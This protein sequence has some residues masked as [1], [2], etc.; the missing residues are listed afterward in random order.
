MERVMA[1]CAWCGN[2]V[3]EVSYAACARCGNPSN[4]SQRV[5]AGGGNATSKSA[6]IVVGILVGGLVLVAIL[7]IV[8]AIAIPNLLT[9]LQRSRQKRTVED[10]RKI[11]TAVDKYATDENRC[12]EGSS[13]D[14]L[15][16]ALVPKYLEAIPKI[17]AWTTQLRYECWPAGASRNYAIGSAGADKTFEHESLEEYG[18][19]TKTSSFDND[20]VFSNGK[21]VQYPEGVQQ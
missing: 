14:D 2:T 3:P 13:V 11:A 10:I 6:G 5:V 12:P 21:F 9:A 4:G 15:A 16:A 1:F 20:I 17:D 19:D 7:G 18:P 8:A